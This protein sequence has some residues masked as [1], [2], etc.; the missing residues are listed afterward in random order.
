MHTR[1]GDD[2]I[3]DRIGAFKVLGRTVGLE[4]GEVGSDDTPADRNDGDNVVD[5]ALEA[6]HICCVCGTEVAAAQS[7]GSRVISLI[8]CC[9]VLTHD[10]GG[11]TTWGCGRTRWW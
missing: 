10:P 3:D 5:G 8:N 1:V 4:C 7:P 9:E 11:S 6:S 2:A